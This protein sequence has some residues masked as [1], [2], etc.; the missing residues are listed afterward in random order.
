MRVQRGVAARCGLIFSEV[1]VQC[2]FGHEGSIVGLLL[3]EEGGGE[4]E[5]VQWGGCLA[6]EGAAAG[7]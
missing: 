3:V 1:V 4:G 7:F 5:R 6:W 2:R